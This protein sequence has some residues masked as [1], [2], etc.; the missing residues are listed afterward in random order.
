MSLMAL[1]F[2]L[3]LHLWPL[4]LIPAALLLLVRPVGRLV[5]FLLGLI[6]F[7]A[8]PYLVDLSGPDNPAGIYPFYGLCISAAAALAEAIGRIVKL[9]RRLRPTAGEEI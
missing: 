7:G 1:I 4:I 2:Q 8:L 5:F 9:V 3:L 6:F